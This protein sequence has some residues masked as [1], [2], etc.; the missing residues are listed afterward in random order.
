M[1]K[2]FKNGMFDSIL[3]T[4]NLYERTRLALSAI[5]TLREIFEEE[6]P[7]I[8]Q[9]ETGEAF[10]ILERKFTLEVNA[11]EDGS[12]GIEKLG[13]IMDQDMVDLEK[14]LREY[15]NPI[16]RDKE[17]KKEA[18]KEN[19]S[20]AFKVFSNDEKFLDE[21]LGE[22]LKILPG[23]EKKVSKIDKEGNI[24]ITR[25][26]DK[27]DTLIEDFIGILDD[28]IADMKNR[29]KCISKKKH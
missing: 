15:K 27:N 11:L 26:D 18:K 17:A 21:L 7:R 16:E 23:K 29:E 28:M 2:Y 10:D 14:M 12:P 9:K 19:C 5:T 6:F 22:I 20:Y 13:D 3:Y 4:K 1:E 24:Y 25:K 8:L